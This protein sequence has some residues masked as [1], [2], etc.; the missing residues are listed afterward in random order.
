M[1]AESPYLLVLL[2][3]AAGGFGH[4]AGMC[5]P[6]VAA[7]SL[8]LPRRGALLSHGLYHLGRTLTYALLGGTV[9]AAGSLLSVSSRLASLQRGAAVLSGLLVALL[10]LV[11]AGW[12]PGR[13]RLEGGAARE[14]GLPSRVLALVARAGAS[15]GTAL[16]AG[17][18]LG[19][20]P[21]GLAYTALLAAA[22]L[23]VDAPSPAAA[24]PRGFLLMTLFG[25]GTAPALLAVGVLAGRLGGAARGRLHAA[26]ALLMVATGLLFAWQGIAR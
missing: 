13:E 11:T 8:G 19:F 5:G 26:A 21:C 25:L 15:P 3:A 24:F 9:A 1:P 18:L 17:I 10:G 23:G 7:F 2:S 14:G 6:L 20:L 16:P 22:R 12:L 4:C